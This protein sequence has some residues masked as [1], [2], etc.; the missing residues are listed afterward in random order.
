MDRYHDSSPIILDPG[1]TQSCRLR[2][3]LPHWRTSHRR[4][5]LP[6]FQSRFAY[7]NGRQTGSYRRELQAVRSWKLV[8]CLKQSHDFV[9][10]CFPRSINTIISKFNSI[11]TPDDSDARHHCIATTK[12]WRMPVE[13]LDSCLFP[14]GIIS[15]CCSSTTVLIPNVTTIATQ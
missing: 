11:Y 12:R 13:A 3:S 4:P 7:V 9:W 1:H 5:L 6:E 15:Q 10:I 8:N 14:Q 2:H